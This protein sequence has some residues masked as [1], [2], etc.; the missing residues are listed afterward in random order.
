MNI[1]IYILLLTVS[2]VSKRKTSPPVSLRVLTT[3]GKT[4]LRKPWVPMEGKSTPLLKR[5][6]MAVK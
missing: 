5:E 2:G 3:R 4:L 6:S 1:Y